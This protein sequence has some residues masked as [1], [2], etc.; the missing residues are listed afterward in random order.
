MA[1]TYILMGIRLPSVESQ[2]YKDTI[3]FGLQ[4][5]GVGLEFSIHGQP[6]QSDGETHH[7]HTYIQ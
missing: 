4:H 2:R 1:H 7:L 5:D 6:I 3:N